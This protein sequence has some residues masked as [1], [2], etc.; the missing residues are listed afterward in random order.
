MSRGRMPQHV[1][2]LRRAQAAK[3]QRRSAEVANP[4]EGLLPSGNYANVQWRFE[5][6]APV[7]RPTFWRYMQPL[8][9]KRGV[10]IY[11]DN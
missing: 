7:G 2:K 6:C 4:R 3:A 8:G 1:R 9:H 10:S 5:F 11:E